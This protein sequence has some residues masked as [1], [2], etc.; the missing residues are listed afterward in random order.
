[1]EA[2][3]AETQATASFEPQVSEAPDF[4]SIAAYESL[5]RSTREIDRAVEKNDFRTVDRLMNDQLAQVM[6]GLFL[7][8]M[9]GGMTGTPVTR[10]MFG[11]HPEVNLQAATL[12]I[13]RR[14]QE[15]DAILSTPVWQGIKAKADEIVKLYKDRNGAD[16]VQMRAGMTPEEMTQAS[17]Q[18]EPIQVDPN[19]IAEFRQ[20]LVEIDKQLRPYG[21]SVWT[22]PRTKRIAETLQNSAE[23]GRPGLLRDAEQNPNDQL[24]PF[25]KYVGAPVVE[26]IDEFVA[27]AA[28]VGIGARDV[29]QQLG[30]ISLDG[31]SNGNADTLYNGPTSWVQDSDG[32]WYHNGGKIGATEVYAGIWHMMTGEL[33]DQQM[34]EYA[35]TKA[36]MAMQATGVQSLAVGLGQ[37]AGSMA[38]FMGTGGPAMKAGA[39]LTKGVGMLVTGGKAAKS[40]SRMEKLATI[41]VQKSGPAAALGVTEAVKSGRV[42]GYGAALLHGT[43]MAVPLMLMGSVGDKLERTLTRNKKLPGFLARGLAGTVEGLGLDL[44]T[45]QS[46]YEVIQDPTDENYAQLFKNV[47]VNMIGNGLLRGSGITGAPPVHEF[48]LPPG[49]QAARK[50]ERREQAATQDPAKVATAR[51]ATPESIQKLGQSFAEMKANVGTNPEG[52]LAAKRNVESA[53]QQ[54]DLE[55]SGMA[56]QAIEQQEA[57][58]ATREEL[59]R[60]KAAP[61][62]PEKRAEIIK[63]LNSSRLAFGKDFPKIVKQVADTSMEGVDADIIRKELLGE[64]QRR[65]QEAPEIA[66][67]EE[68]QIAGMAKR[69]GISVEE[70]KAQ[71]NDDVTPDIA[72][73]KSEDDEQSAIDKLNKLKDDFKKRGEEKL[74]APVAKLHD[75][76]LKNAVEIERSWMNQQPIHPKWERF[77]SRSSRHQSERL[78]KWD[79]V[80]PAEKEEYSQ[81][82][83]SAVE[84]G[85]FPTIDTATEFIKSKHDAYHQATVDKWEQEKRGYYNR[86][87][88]IDPDIVGVREQV[89]GKEPGPLKQVASK[90][91]INPSDEMVQEGGRTGLEPDQTL[92]PKG[93]PAP[94]PLSPEQALTEGRDLETGERA[95]LLQAPPSQRPGQPASL[96]MDPSRE[97]E[98]Q[99]GTKPIRASDIFLSLE[100]FEGD[101]FRT[102]FRKGVGIRGRL[103]TRGVLGWHHTREDINRLQDSRHI[104]AGFHEWSHD[105]DLEAGGSANLLD[106]KKS[107]LTRDQMLGFMAVAHPWY[108]GYAD[109]P[110]RSKEMESW[111]EFWARYMLDDPQLRADAGP[112]YDYA[113]NW[114]ANPAR[115]GVLRLVQRHS[116]LFR[117]YRDQG[118]IARGEKAIVFYDDPKSLQELQAAGIM[119]DTPPAR[120]MGAVRKV[121]SSLQ[122][123]VYDDLSEMKSAQEN[124]L[125]RA[126]DKATADRIRLEGSI[127]HDPVRMTD[128]Y[129]MTATRQA[130]RFL[131]T[132]THDLAGNTNG[133][134]LKSIFTET[135]RQD[136]YRDFSNW[137]AAMRRLEARNAGLE[138]VGPTSRADDL[139]IAE[140]LERPEYRTAAKQLRAYWDRVIDYA[141]EA[142]AFSAEQAA[143]IKGSYEFYIPFERVLAK[144]KSAGQ[145]RGVAERG[146]GVKTMRGSTEE[147]RDPLNAMADMT[148]NII[149]KAQQSMVM[150]AAVLH[151]IVHD[152]VGSFVTEVKRNVIAKDH[153]M[154]AI[155]DALRRASEGADP[156]VA[157]SVGDM[158]TLLEQLAEAGEIGAAVTLFGQQTI[159]KGGRPVI[160]YTPHFSAADMALLTPQQQ[161]LARDKNDKLIWLEM[162]K[163]AYE[164]LMGLDIPPNLM[165]KMPAVV[166]GVARAATYLDRLGATILN[167][168][169]LL[170]N[171]VRDMVIW[172][173]TTRSKTLPGPLSIFSAMGAYAKGVLAIARQTPSAAKMENLGTGVGTFFG[174]EFSRG[175][176]AQELLGMRRGIVSNVRAGVGSMADVLGK[177]ELALRQREFK[178]TY[179]KQIAAGRS[180]IEASLTA[181]EAAQN[182]ITKFTRGGVLT[183]TMNSLVPYTTAKT[184]SAIRL[185]EV[186][187]GRK[188]ADLQRQAIVRGISLIT[189]PSIA[190]WWLNR[191]EEWYREMPEWEKLNFWHFKLPGTD[192][193]IKIP[194]PFEWGKLFGNMPEVLLERAFEEDPR[195]VIDTAWDATSS[196]VP[197][198]FMPSIAQ[199]FIEGMSNYDFFRQREVVPEWMERSRLPKDQFTA[200]TRWYAKAM[201]TALGFAGLDV[202]PIRIERALDS[203]TGGLV[204]RTNDF[205]TDLWALQKLV[206]DEDFQMSDVPVAGRAFVRKNPYSQAV[207][208]QKLYDADKHLT[209]M[210]GSNELDQSGQADRQMVN[211]AKEEVSRL[212]ALAREGKMDQVEAD[213]QAAKVARE[214]LKR[215]NR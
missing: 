215:I 9:Q 73:V 90:A 97:M 96:R 157:E 35:D 149:T 55:E 51:N 125:I 71:L 128:V 53:E 197:T 161:R 42:E 192:E 117:R 111:A 79:D 150:K 44:G 179:D 141:T 14:T 74:N 80:A 47:T 182:I 95:E 1:M 115:L 11:S 155:A 209:Q 146:T 67:D 203:T 113:M 49:E 212:K 181:L 18:F 68:A 101:A 211:R 183:R 159:P 62:T 180:D 10:E 34:A 76:P 163:H 131:V 124:A 169:F 152:G 70:M 185:A 114:I 165:D 87:E 122:K 177:G 134:S 171:P 38:A 36:R 173:L 164:S 191:D 154:T 201:T 103:S 104:T 65:A 137:I 136:Q 196:M 20:Q 91:R 50:Q 142:G 30:V 6:Q 22:D 147:I 27:G 58:Y 26:G 8:D 92:P 88:G 193:P 39:S 145:G 45:W 187:S 72:G 162:D 7:A 89:P 48:G 118:A 46:A 205:F 23:P 167:P 69:L 194:K 17:M 60:L 178:D 108:P 25:T 214:T 12:Q 61:N 186:L 86:S 172:A 200:Y 37:F 133:Q 174:H 57:R 75:D 175:R 140:R 176:T 54:L 78:E 207:S 93:P 135:L 3:T 138:Q 126:T 63:L 5:K 83:K 119:R 77:L 206:N 189:V 15:T 2:P 158:S 59:D 66:A 16:K 28:Q 116:E 64:Q 139:Y 127:M 130:E 195:S 143:A 144:V 105:M 52:A 170:S 153:P 156:D 84:D 213:R 94:R 188:G 106:P 110:R 29:L 151:G 198:N 99:P 129:Q 202:S 210:A 204:G 123:V 13:V 41:M 33:I 160:A 32:T 190:L 168:T 43:V 148:R 112:F 120:A 132:G 121:T 21:T 81:L 40:L 166:G 19:E 24:D 184:N 85:L 4:G 100:G 199:P 98:G 208:V 109:L 31:L 107:P 102:T 56:L 82:A